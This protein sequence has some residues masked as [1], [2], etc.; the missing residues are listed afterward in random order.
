MYV[1]VIIYPTGADSSSA[2][3]SQAFYDLLAFLNGAVMEK[4]QAYAAE[5]ASAK[6]V[7]KAAQLY[8]HIA[9]IFSIS[10]RLQRLALPNLCEGSDVSYFLRQFLS[11]AAYVVA[12]HSKQA[13][14]DTKSDGVAAVSRFRTS[15]AP[16]TKTQENMTATPISDVFGAIE[17]VRGIVMRWMKSSTP[18]DINSAIDKMVS[19][20]LQHSFQE[21]SGW[22][23]VTSKPL[24]CTQVIESE[25]PYS[26]STDW[27]QTVC[28]PGSSSINLYFDIKS[29]TE[30]DRD[31]V[32]VSY[33]GSAPIRLQGPSGST[34]PGASGSPALN[35]PGDIF[36]ISFHSDDSVQEWG[37]KVEAVANVCMEAAKSLSKES[38]LGLYACQL[39]LKETANYV[40]EARVYMATHTALLIEQEEK[41]LRGRKA[42]EDEDV[43]VGLFQD[44][45]GCVV[46]HP[47][48]Q[49][50][51]CPPTCVPLV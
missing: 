50:F 4:L 34:W 37:F 30:P 9:L 27:T 7:E 32:V 31:Y 15:P 6:N 22:Q 13:N 21:S 44:S 8:T 26:P 45:T 10:V 19:T 3:P 5:A 40:D 16:K 28:F 41:E 43:S 47:Y 33:P 48:F 23:K 24:V 42:E 36:I 1:D 2:V 12:W 51:S 14:E 38:G 46:L 20:S 29:C 17:Q 49:Y 25:H 35:I 18:Q 39:A 11:S